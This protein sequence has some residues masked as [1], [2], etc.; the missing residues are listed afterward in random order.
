[1]GTLW[2]GLGYVTYQTPAH[3]AGQ[4]HRIV[5][6]R[7]LGGTGLLGMEPTA[8]GPVFCLFPP[9]ASCLLL[10][11]P[12][13]LS[14]FFFF[15]FLCFLLPPFPSRTTGR[16]QKGWLVVFFF[17]CADS[18]AATTFMCTWACFRARDFLGSSLLLP[19]MVAAHTLRTDVVDGRQAVSGGRAHR[20]L[21]APASMSGPPHLEPPSGYLVGVLG[22]LARGD[23]HGAWA[24]EAPVVEIAKVAYQAVGRYD[25]SEEEKNGIALHLP[26]SPRAALRTQA[27]NG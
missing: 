24:D 9:S 17:F 23:A 2:A 18:I 21:R 12:S 3:C 27:T 11:L 7:L 25:V 10:V 8:F 5:K 16:I 22:G 20:V 1:M 13:F 6:M 19:D 26:T 14:F 4:T 15:C